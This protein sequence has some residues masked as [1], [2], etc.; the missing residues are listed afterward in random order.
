MTLS[1][2]VSLH[3]ITGRNESPLLICRGDQ[4]P[5][6]EKS[7]PQKY[8][9]DSRSGCGIPEEGLSEP[10]LHVLSP[11]LDPSVYVAT[12]DYNGARIFVKRSSM[13]AQVGSCDLRYLIYTASWITP[14]LG[15][16]DR[17]ALLYT[18]RNTSATYIQSKPNFLAA[19][20]NR[21]N[22]LGPYVSLNSKAES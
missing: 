4:Q 21:Y 3:I 19:L 10:D 22:R 15:E 6:Q 2:T 7:T 8:C 18:S 16:G 11:D 5:R 13:T 12:L 14:P 1:L 17:W 20:D 9:S